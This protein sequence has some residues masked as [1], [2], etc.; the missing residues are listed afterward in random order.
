MSVSEYCGTTNGTISATPATSAKASLQ[1]TLFFLA[2]QAA[3]T[4]DEDDQHKEVHQREREV[5]EIVGAE[6][7][8][9]AHQHAA[10]DRAEERAHAADDNDH[11]SGDHHV[12][13][14]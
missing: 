14:H 12:G 11:E 2:Q 10:D 3:G 7:L 5:L 4:R 1:D 13:P 6:H 9:E 8:H